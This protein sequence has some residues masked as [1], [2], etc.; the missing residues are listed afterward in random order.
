MGCLLT[1]DIKD[2]VLKVI[3]CNGIGLKIKINFSKS[4][5]KLIS[6]HE[7]ICNDTTKTNNDNEFEVI[8]PLRTI[9]LNDSIFGEN[10]PSFS[11]STKEFV[12][13]NNHF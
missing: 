3:C 5:Y 4:K 7:W 9:S 6:N 13:I 8:E 11:D 12:S 10:Q 1:Y 2:E